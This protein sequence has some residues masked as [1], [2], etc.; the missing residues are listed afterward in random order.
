MIKQTDINKMSYQEILDL[1]QVLDQARMNM[2]YKDSSKDELYRT[3]CKKRYTS[4]K[5][6]SFACDCLLNRSE[7]DRE[8]V[9]K[10]KEES[11]S[12]YV[13]ICCSNWLEKNK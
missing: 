5:E 12:D 3:A 13:V 9:L 10:L 4:D 1:I 8:L 7:I 11:S 6:A 2:R